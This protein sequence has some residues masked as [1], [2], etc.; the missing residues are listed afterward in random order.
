MSLNTP[1]KRRAA[2]GVRRLPG[3]TPQ[4]AKGPSWRKQV[5]R[6][7]AA[8]DGVIVPPVV[9]VSKSVLGSGIY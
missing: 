4:V 8:S 6:G 2:A 1:S 5:A 7:Y 3:V 9:M